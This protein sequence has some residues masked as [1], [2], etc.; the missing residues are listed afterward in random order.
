[1]RKRGLLRIAAIIIALN[2]FGSDVAIAAE[3]VGPVMATAAI[4]EEKGEVDKGDEVLVASEGVTQSDE[5]TDDD[6]S[7]VLPTTIANGEEDTSVDEGTTEASTEEATLQESTEEG[8]TEELVEA[9]TVVEETEEALDIALQPELIDKSVIPDADGYESRVNEWN[10]FL[11]DDSLVAGVDYIDGAF[12]FEADNKDEAQRIAAIYGG[13]LLGYSY[14]V[15]EMIFSDASTKGVMNSVMGAVRAGNVADSILPSIYPDLLYHSEDFDRDEAI[16]KLD[17]IEAAKEQVDFS[18]ITW[19][20]IDEEPANEM[21]NEN[22]L[23]DEQARN[24]MNLIDESAAEPEE[25]H[26]EIDSEGNVKVYEDGVLVSEAGDP[27]DEVSAEYEN[28]P[29]LEYLNATHWQHTVNGDYVAWQTSIGSGITVAV[30]DSGA[31]TSHPDISYI[32]AYN[33]ISANFS[34]GFMAWWYGGSYNGAKDNNGHGTHCA[35]IIGAHGKVVGVAPGAKIISIKALEQSFFGDGASGST[36]SIVRAENMAVAKGARIVSMSL[37]GP[38]PQDMQRTAMQNGVNKGVVFVCAAGNESCSE[39]RAPV[40]YKDLCIGVSAGRKRTTVREAALD[41]DDRYSNYGDYVD[42]MAPGTDI[43]STYLHNGYTT[44]SGTSMAT[45][46]VSGACALYLE[47]NKNLLTV[48]NKDFVDTVKNAVLMSAFN[49]STGTQTSGRISDKVGYGCLNTRTLVGGGYNVE[50]FAPRFSTYGGYIHEGYRVKLSSS[51]GSDAIRYTLDGTVPTEYSRRTDAGGYI[52]IPRGVSKVTVKAVAFSGSQKSPVSTVTYNIMPL[53][54]DVPGVN[55]KHEYALPRQ[56]QFVNYENIS[57]YTKGTDMPYQLYKVALN[58]GDSVD[59]SLNAAGFNGEL[60]ILEG[61]TVKAYDVRPATQANAAYKNARKLSYTRSATGSGYVTIC[62]TSGVLVTGTG[63]GSGDYGKYTLNVKVNRVPTGVTVTV[64][65]SELGSGKSMQATANV[66]PWDAANKKVIWSLVNPFDGSPISSD[67]ATVNSKGVV[68]AKGVTETIPIYV[69]AT[70]V[71]SP[72]GSEIYGGHYVEIKPLVTKVKLDSSV[73]SLIELPVNMGDAASEYVLAPK[74]AI[75][76]AGA[77]AFVSYKSSNSKVATV[78]QD[79][80]IKVLKTGTAKI[81][82]TALDGSKKSTSITVKGINAATGVY[83]NP[84]IVPGTCVDYPIVPGGKADIV[85]TITPLNATYKRVTYIL[86]KP[87]E[88]LDIKMNGK[89]VIVGDSVPVGTVFTV[90]TRVDNGTSAI[91]PVDY[92]VGFVVMDSVSGIKLAYVDENQKTTITGSVV[93]LKITNSAGD[94]LSDM[95]GRTSLASNN[96]NVARIE[97]YAGQPRIRTIGR[98]KARITLKAADGSG[99]S[100]YVDV[101][102]VAPVESIEVTTASLAPANPSYEYALPMGVKTNLKANILPANANNKKVTWELIDPVV[103]GVTISSSGQ[104]NVPKSIPANTKIKVKATAT[105]GSG[106]EDISTFYTQPSVSKVEFTAKTAKINAHLAPIFEFAAKGVGTSE[107]ILEGVTYTSSN[108][109]VL[110]INDRTGEA[111]A[112]KKGT[113]TITA[114]SVDGSGKKASVRVSVVVPIINGN[115]TNKTGVE[116]SGRVVLLTGNNTVQLKNINSYNPLGS[117]SNKNY[118]WKLLDNYDQ[119]LDSKIATVN[120]RGVVKVN[121]SLTEP[122]LVKIMVEPQEGT[123]FTQAA[124]I[125]P[126]IKTINLI[127]GTAKRDIVIAKSVSLAPVSTIPIN[128]Y[129]VYTYKS[130]NPKVASV[131]SSGNVIG[132]SRGTATI[133]IKAADGSGKSVKV[134]VTVH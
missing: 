68:K 16:E 27:L 104:I 42:I 70:S 72:E 47:C 110:W 57:G 7:E 129:G 45:P 55:Y 52:S 54:I 66:E 10:T 28:K 5:G 79:G 8:T 43:Y 26:E 36:A 113:A 62:V 121:S 73:G 12:A 80:S 96:E 109:S 64:P 19:E 81:T 63:I 130:S 103:E 91:S 112:Y 65:T 23:S 118:K 40:S 116:Y 32:G 86:E 82:V 14:G 29:D 128:A 25:I 3:Y 126:R 100:S 74:V 84:S 75:E 60:Y 124:E 46:M 58:K 117:P 97:W 98:G 37:G 85:S 21:E 51:A 107:G 120:S 48:K 105:D 114:T 131:N 41:F 119:P 53:T 50:T 1:M 106:V 93:N 111:H 87:D 9:I 59:V 102:V 127:G 90:K 56:G 134:K 99:M 44:L 77:S 6:T 15:G 78:D 71:A 95:Y 83:S 4:T 76:P 22:I 122:M 35:G 94:E 34:N 11:A 30:I 39:K 67:Y 33:A 17:E 61:S 69:K 123:A 2:M 133:T 101:N 24:Y 132:I 88:N 89:K 92:S 125:F 38:Y 31:T 18:S 20:S 13:T 49:P 115:I 108:P